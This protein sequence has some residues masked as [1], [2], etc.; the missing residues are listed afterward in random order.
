MEEESAHEP[1][2]GRP[3]GPKGYWSQRPLP[4]G[5]ARQRLVEARNYWVASVLPGGR[6]HA[7]PVWGVWLDEQFYFDTG[8]RIG[9]N[10]LA[11]PEVTVHLES[12]DQVVIIEGTAERVVDPA[13]QGRFLESYNPN[14]HAQFAAP[15]GVV[16]AVRPRV[17]IGWLSDPTGLD[18]GATFGNTGT[19]WD[20]EK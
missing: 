13:R 10:L 17:A 9:S 4:W 6:P 18:G 15:P 5:W 8:S 16:F 11:R 19:R 20:F 7:R 2:A 12:G 3:A 14:Y 1:R